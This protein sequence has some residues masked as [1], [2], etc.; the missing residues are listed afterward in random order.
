[1]LAKSW[2]CPLAKRRCSKPACK[3]GETCERRQVPLFHVEQLHA[4]TMPDGIIDD[5]DIG[6]CVYW[7]ETGFAIRTGEEEVTIY[8]GTSEE[9]GKTMTMPYGRNA[10]NRMLEE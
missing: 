4:P 7:I 10:L 3:R 2:K 5:I 6:D 1:M 8:C 9:P